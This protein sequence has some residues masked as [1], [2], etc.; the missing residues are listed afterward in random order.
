MASL[1]KT[2]F[3]SA[4]DFDLRQLQAPLAVIA[5]QQ[6]LLCKIKA[7]LP[8]EI[9]AHI[10]HCVVSGSRLIIYAEAASWASQIRF[11]QNEILASLV[12]SGQ[13]NINSLQVRIGLNQQLYKSERSANLPSSANIQ[14]LNAQ[15]E[16][17]T[18]DDVLATALSRLA[19][20][21]EKKSAAK[22]QES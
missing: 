13:K 20:T 15:L 1:N 22:Q 9:A 18:T 12:A 14:S 16:N 19:K 21:L 7:I 5:A 8:A 10:Q 11:Y 2:V 3:K 4:L 17:S 6:A